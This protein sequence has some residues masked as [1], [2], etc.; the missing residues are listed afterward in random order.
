LEKG[1]VLGE[2][3][4]GGEKEVRGSKP[5]NQTAGTFNRDNKRNARVKGKGGGKG[6]DGIGR[7]LASNSLQ[8]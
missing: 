5:K 2:G 4:L 3:K 6:V 8:L 7:E 1:V